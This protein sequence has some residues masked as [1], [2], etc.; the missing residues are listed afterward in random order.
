VVGQLRNV[1]RNV[2]TYHMYKAICTSHSL[3]HLDTFDSD[4]DHPMAS[5][6]MEM[7]VGDNGVVAPSQ[8]GYYKQQTAS[9]TANHTSKSHNMCHMHLTCTYT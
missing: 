1:T 5:L 6:A 9:P 3:T 8:L 4:I 2:V 7:E